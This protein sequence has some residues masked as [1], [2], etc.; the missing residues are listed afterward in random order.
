M[1]ADA[2]KRQALRHHFHADEKSGF[3]FSKLKAALVLGQNR[4]W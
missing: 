2:I 3:E 1:K 4:L